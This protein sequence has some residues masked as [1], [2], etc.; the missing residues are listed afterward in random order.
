[1]EMRTGR[2]S[3]LKVGSPNPDSLI[4]NSRRQ[5]SR[6][7]ATA[8]HFREA[9]CDIG[10]AATGLAAQRGKADIAGLTRGSE[11]DF[12]AVIGTASGNRILALLMHILGGPDA[13][14]PRRPERVLLMTQIADALR[15][16]DTA[17]GRRLFLSLAQPEAGA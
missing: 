4:S 1:V 5:L 17:A 9:L 13:Q 6:M 16:R 15:V 10:V 3:G 11:A 12:Y 7:G 2:H 14:R 8:A